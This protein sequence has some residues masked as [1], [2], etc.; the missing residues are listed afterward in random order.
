ML[1]LNFPAFQ[2]ATPPEETVAQEFPIS[3]SHATAQLF[4]LG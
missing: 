4:H 3:P 2:K 1:I